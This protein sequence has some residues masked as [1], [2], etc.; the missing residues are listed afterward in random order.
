MGRLPIEF[1]K[2]QLKDRNPTMR[3]RNPIEFQAYTKQWVEK[4][5]PGTVFHVQDV[6]K[7]LESSFPD[8]CAQSGLTPEYA[9]APAEPTWKHNAR[10]VLDYCA[11]QGLL[12]HIEESPNQGKWLRL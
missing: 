6:Y 12:K 7:Y 2:F 11:R 10:Q 8:E 3:E 5:S 9:G 1:P 4:L